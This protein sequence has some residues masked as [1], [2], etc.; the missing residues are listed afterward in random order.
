MNTHWVH[1]MCKT[2]IYRVPVHQIMLARKDKSSE[3]RLAGRTP[4]FVYF[5]HSLVSFLSPDQMDWEKIESHHHI[6]LKEPRKSLLSSFSDHINTHRNVLCW[7]PLQEKVGGP[8]AWYES[9]LCDLALTIINYK[10][11]PFLDIEKSVNKSRSIQ[12]FFFLQVL[13][14]SSLGMCA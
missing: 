4:E 2:F 9:I 11:T 14:Q 3:Q 8:F 7:S 6:I 13:R 5:Q 1:D 10:I 12:S